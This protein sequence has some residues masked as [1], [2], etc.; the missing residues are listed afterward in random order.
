MFAD[1]EIA[2]DVLQVF[3]RINGQMDESVLAIENRTSPDEFTAFKRAVGHVMFEVFERI[4]EPICERHP[5][6]K[7]PDMKT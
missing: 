6:L 2:K 5:Q 7:P 4:V 3:L 1:P